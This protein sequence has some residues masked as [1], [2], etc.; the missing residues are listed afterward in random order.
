MGVKK[1]RA[2]DYRFHD[3]LPAAVYSTI[4]LDLVDH[5]I[6]WVGDIADATGTTIWNEMDHRH[7]PHWWSTLTT[8]VTHDKSS[9]LLTPVSPN[10][11]PIFP[12]TKHKIGSVVFLPNENRDGSFEHVTKGYCY[13]VTGHTTDEMNR[14]QCKLLHLKTFEGRMRYAAAHTS[15]NFQ[16]VISHTSVMYLRPR[17]VE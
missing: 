3:A 5:G 17:T 4:L 13:I 12:T 16:K 1:T 11:N 2:T 9:T 14:P 7:T 8:A 6:R 10:T 15:D